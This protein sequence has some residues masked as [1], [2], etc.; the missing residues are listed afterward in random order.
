MV[1]L[2]KYGTGGNA[3][4]SAV[5]DLQLESQSLGI[6]YVQILSQLLFLKDK[7]AKTKTETCN[8]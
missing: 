4:A 5:L 2:N 7:Q 1:S 3:I 6:Y 8:G